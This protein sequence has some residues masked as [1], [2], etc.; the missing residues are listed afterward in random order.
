MV[1]GREVRNS[2]SVSALTFK[3]HVD[4]GQIISLVSFGFFFCR[5]NLG[6]MFPVGLYDPESERFI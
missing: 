4:L 6:Q 3:S 1:L 5:D 2:S